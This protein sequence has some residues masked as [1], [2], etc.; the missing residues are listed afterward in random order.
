M[1]PFMCSC[2]WTVISENLSKKHPKQSY[3]PLHI[4][5]KMKEKPVPRFFEV[6]PSSGVLPPGET[7]NVWIRFIPSE[8]VRHKQAIIGGGRGGGD[9]FQ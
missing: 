4:R 5:K 2:N 7:K 3:I 1:S 8:Q 9:K 6:K